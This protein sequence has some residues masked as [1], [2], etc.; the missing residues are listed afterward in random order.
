MTS[1]HLET[2]TVSEYAVLLLINAADCDFDIHDKE[3]EYIK[4]RYGDEQYIKMRKFYDQDK[5]GSFSKLIR[6]MNVNENL[7]K[8]KMTMLKE[9]FEVLQSDGIYN[10]FE[11]AFYKFFKDI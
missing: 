1:I 5:T 2:L 4:A 9:V 8:E 3:V 11:K 7:A 6:E 10:D